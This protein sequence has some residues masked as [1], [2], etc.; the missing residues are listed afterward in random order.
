MHFHG[1]HSE[2]VISH[3]HLELLDYLVKPQSTASHTPGK[4]HNGTD[5]RLVRHHFDLLPSGFL[6]RLWSK[7][8]KQP[9]MKRVIIMTA[10]HVNW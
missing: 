1:T 8:L 10:S 9:V 2:L 6:G 4:S 5:Y 3:V 7:L